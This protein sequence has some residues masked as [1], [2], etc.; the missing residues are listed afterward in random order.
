MVSDR[1]V[2]PAD[3]AGWNDLRARFRWQIST[4]FNIAERCCDSWAESEPD[5]LA[6]IDV[7]A[8]GT[9]R[10]WRY[11]DLYRAANRL[12]RVLQARGVTAGDRVAILLPQ[13]PDVLIAHFAA[14]KLG[15][16]ALP[17]FTLFGEDA[18]RFRLE[19]SG[20]AA[21]IT[22]PANL[23]KVEALTAVLPGVSTIGVTG[24]A[25]APFLDLPVETARAS[26]S[27]IRAE[28]GPDDPAVMI[29]TSGTTGSPKGALHA[30]RFLLGHLPS[31]ELHHEWFP[32]PGD[33][34][35]TPAD[36][37]W[38][39]G[40]MDMALP[41]LHYGV[42]LVSHRAAKFDPDEAYAL[43]ARHA[44]RNLF[45]P[46]TA[47]RLM[48]QA[49]V[50]A[51]V[52]IRSIGSGGESLGPELLDWGETA[53][54]LKINEFYGQTECNLVVSTSRGIEDTPPGAMGRAV[55]GHD[56]AVIDAD[57]EPAPAGESG[58]IAVRRGTPVMFL[59]YW[60][61]PEKT[62]EKFTGEWMRTGDL[63]TCDEGGTFR[64][65]ARDD[66]VITS[67]GYRIGP[68]EIESCLA[69]HPQ[70]VMAAAVGLPDPVRTEVVTAFVVFRDG[71]DPAALEKEL[72]DRVRTRISPHVAPRRIVPVPSLPM[73][74][75]GKIMRRT[76]RERGA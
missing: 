9:A 72:I 23:P 33:R 57:G 67:S 34:G 53:L 75:T 7:A 73:T 45:L 27:P 62:E 17:L 20:A 40:L 66:D 1:T 63:G 42:P 14:Y 68:T 69:G 10:E 30:H 39:G 44:V 21:I 35:W 19:D 31:I 24:A 61:Q 74:A 13:G 50:P 54:G 51:G 47:L 71:A 22:D 65:V 49:S 55:P 59:R 5:R 64:F 6:V 52:D 15:A 32:S 28:T 3:G 29:Y 76:L 46:P 26:D 12:A 43:I 38:I 36:W 58:E 25:Q 2:L 16:I 37:A 11:I 18:L 8:D 41:C 56:V 48:R 70:V 4:R 60:N